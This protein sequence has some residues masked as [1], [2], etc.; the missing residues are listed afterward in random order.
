MADIQTSS[1]AVRVFDIPELLE[2]ILI[3][4]RTSCHTSAV[5][6]AQEVKALFRL[7][8]V[9]TTFRDVITSRKALR[10]LIFKESVDERKTHKKSPEK[11]TPR[12][13][14]PLVDHYLSCLKPSSTYFWLTD[15]AGDRRK[16]V[17]NV[18]IP[19]GNHVETPAEDAMSWRDLLVLSKSRAWSFDI[20][21]CYRGDD[22]YIY[23]VKLKKDAR[24]RDL[25]VKLVDVVNRYVKQKRRAQDLLRLYPADEAR[26]GLAAIP[27]NPTNWSNGPLLLSQ[28]HTG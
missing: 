10:R 4:I 14:N 11:A 15:T 17:M 27:L 20:S 18:L 9:N 24:L 1:A 16:S 7:Q 23:N 22:S 3:S 12:C 28:S 25:T 6:H 13:I 5:N 2:W 21:I 26:S 8:R 19:T